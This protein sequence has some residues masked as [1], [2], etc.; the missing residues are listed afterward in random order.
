MLCEVLQDLDSEPAARQVESLV[1]RFEIAPIA[2]E[3]IAV[4]A[5]RNFRCLRRRGVTIHDH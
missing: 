4:I 1:R 2:G 3:V 5:A